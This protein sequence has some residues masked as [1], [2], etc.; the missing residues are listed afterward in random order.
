MSYD[1]SQETPEIV[2]EPKKPKTIL[3]HRPSKGEGL[4]PRQHFEDAETGKK[5]VRWWPGSVVKGLAGGV[6][7]VGDHGEV[8]SYARQDKKRKK[9]ERLIKAE[10]NRLTNKGHRRQAEQLQLELDQLIESWKT[11]PTIQTKEPP[12]VTQEQEREAA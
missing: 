9:A 4:V 1:P 2:E 5:M 3:L 10:I 11:T 8:L 6:Y 7:I 12:P